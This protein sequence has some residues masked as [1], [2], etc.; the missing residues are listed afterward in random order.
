MTDSLLVRGLWF[1]LIGW[2]LTGLW[3]TVAWLLIVT[4]VGI[5]FGIAMISRTPMVLT[6]KGRETD[7]RSGVPAGQPHGLLAR[8]VWFVLIGWWASG[9]WTSVAY[10]FALT[11]VGLPVAI[12][13]F[14]YLPFIV[15]L[16]RY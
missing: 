1:L 14:H 12:V 13:M 6:L 4:I 7:H 15:S 8:A 5:P 2:W 9:I 3:L 10:L 16:Y 11:I